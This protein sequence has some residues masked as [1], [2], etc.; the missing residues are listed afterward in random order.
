LR[1]APLEEVREYL[2]GVVKDGNLVALLHV[3]L[4]GEC[5]GDVKDGNFIALLH[6]KASLAT[7]SFKL[8]TH[9]HLGGIG[10]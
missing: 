5:S 2:G 6:G 3:R 10:S 9:H 8:S 7:T 4:V 1:V